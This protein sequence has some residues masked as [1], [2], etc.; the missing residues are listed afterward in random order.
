MLNTKLL[1]SSV[2]SGLLVPL[3]LL[4]FVPEWF[5]SPSPSHPP[6]L[7]FTAPS[8]DGDT[9]V[10][11][12]HPSLMPWGTSLSFGAYSYTCGGEGVTIKSNDENNRRDFQLVLRI[13]DKIGEG[14][15]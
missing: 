1:L 13:V 6:S 9:V 2:S 15:L 14:R 3:T 5:P 12:R 4:Y 8:E 11:T 10:A 7:G